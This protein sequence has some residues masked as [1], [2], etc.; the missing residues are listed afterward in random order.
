MR[1]LL[2]VGLIAG[3]AGFVALAALQQLVGMVALLGILAVGALAGLGM[4]KWLAWSWFGRQLEAGWRV[5]ALACGMAG[6]GALASLFWLGPQDIGQLADRSH[7]A[8]L[9]FGP[10]IRGLSA[11]TWAGV[12]GLGILAATGLGIGL[13]ALVTWVFAAGKS[14]RTVQAITL[15]RQA[16]HASSKTEP[17]SAVAGN[18]PFASAPQ[19]G[20]DWH[21]APG[22]MPPSSNISPWSAPKTIPSLPDAPHA[23]DT[24]PAQRNPAR[25]D[26]SAARP[27]ER[28]LSAAD[29]EAI[30]QWTEEEDDDANAETEKRR[31]APPS[32]YLNSPPP[33]TAPRRDRK[34]QQTRDWL[35]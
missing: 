5:G 3:V 20:S 2:Q 9:D 11:L 18:Y 19:S 31:T 14:A 34:K 26:P 25:R 24:G 7:L 33:E 22:M 27:P 30:R 21:A 15:A 4:A 29:R 10:V 32:T 28:E 17:L 1:A 35:C 16:A 23:G 12:S 6:L 13:A 8:G